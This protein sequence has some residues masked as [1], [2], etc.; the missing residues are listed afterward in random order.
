M[1]VDKGEL[2]QCRG[3]TGFLKHFCVLFCDLKGDLSISMLNR[4]WRRGRGG[5]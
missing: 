5:A 1:Q 2:V 4:E 3:L